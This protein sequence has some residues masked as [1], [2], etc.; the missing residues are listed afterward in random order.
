MSE[1]SYYTTGSLR[2]H[3][4][5]QAN[6]GM[7]TGGF[8]RAW[9]CIIPESA[10]VARVFGIFVHLPIATCN[11]Y[12][13]GSRADIIITKAVIHITILVQTIAQA[14]VAILNLTVAECITTTPGL[15][16][17]TVGQVLLVSA[18]KI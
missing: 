11:G 2:H 9:E 3:S 5:Y 13:I 12:D 17:I 7:L 10:R 1:S 16:G 8:W 4:Y 18:Q 14:T 15:I 6:T